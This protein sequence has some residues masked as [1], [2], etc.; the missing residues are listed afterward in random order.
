MA[1]KLDARTKYKVHEKN[2]HTIYVITWTQSQGS[3]SE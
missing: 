2:Y 1:L 3:T